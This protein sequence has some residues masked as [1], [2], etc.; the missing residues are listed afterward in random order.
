MEVNGGNND[1]GKPAHAGL[2]NKVAGLEVL[3][4]LFLIVPSML[5]SFFAVKVGSVNFTMVG[6]ATILRD[7]ALVFL[8]LFFLWR[9]GER[10]SE[11]GWK[12]RKRWKDILLGVAI[13][14]PFFFTASLVDRLL[15]DLGFSVPAT[16]M[17]FPGATKSVLEILLAFVLVVIVAWAEET[18]FRGYLILRFKPITGS[19]LAA[20]LLSSFVFSLGHGYEG[21]AGVITVGF[22]GFVF[23]LVYLWR[24][25]LVAPMTIHF[26]QDLSGILIL[27]M[28]GAH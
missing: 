10:V 28:L 12:F 11:I 13:F 14:I 7:L 24:E 6:V 27:P 9:N 16:P 15:Q 26:L 17:P 22:M 25:S 2:S 4:F 19:P 21:S 20:V 18:I 5:F 3:V 8:V 1:D 23:G